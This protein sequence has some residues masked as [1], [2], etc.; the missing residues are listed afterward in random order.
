MSGAAV[1]TQG[2]SLLGNVCISTLL[3]V[4]EWRNCER[5]VVLRCVDIVVYRVDTL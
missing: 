5:I 1:C 3:S 2:G 4:S